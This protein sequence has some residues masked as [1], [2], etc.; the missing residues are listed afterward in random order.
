LD[1]EDSSFGVPVTQFEE[2]S[3]VVV[4]AKGG[5]GEVV[6][7]CHLQGVLEQTMASS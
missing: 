6:V 7:E 2:I 3:E 4:S 1:S 5:D